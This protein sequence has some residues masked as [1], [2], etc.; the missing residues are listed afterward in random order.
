MKSQVHERN[1]IN[2]LG[3]N[4]IHKNV[5]ILLNFQWDLTFLQY[6]NSAELLRFIFQILEDIMCNHKSDFPK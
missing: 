5:F 3:I 4:I 1:Y 2:I 6:I